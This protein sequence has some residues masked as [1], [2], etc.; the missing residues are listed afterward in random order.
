MQEISKQQVEAGNVY[1]IIAYI[2]NHQLCSSGLFY[3]SGCSTLKTFQNHLPW[4]PKYGDLAKE[5]KKKGTQGNSKQLVQ[6]Q[7][8]VLVTESTDLFSFEELE[9]SGSALQK[10][11]TTT[12]VSMEYFRFT[13]GSSNPR[14]AADYAEPC[15]GD[16]FGLSG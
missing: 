9:G 14:V 2:F 12:A 7:Q 10:N 4:S 13:T 11:N 5:K 8:L 16:L 15:L 6:S 3:A 1:L